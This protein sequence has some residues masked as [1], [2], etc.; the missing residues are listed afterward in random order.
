LQRIFCI[1]KARL[2]LELQQ[3]VIQGGRISLTTD[4]WSTRNYSEYAAVTA[5]WISDKWQLRCTVLDVIELREPI[6]SGEYLAEQLLAVTN[7]YHITPAVFT[8]TCDNA[9]T[10]TVM[11]SEYENLV[12]M[13]E[14]TL[15]Q[16]WAYITKEGNVRCIGHIINLAVQAALASL[17]AVP[18]D[19]PDAYRL[20]YEAARVPLLLENESV[21]VLSKL[22]RYIY[23]FRNR[24][25]WKDA[26]KKQCKAAN[27]EFKQLSLNMP[28]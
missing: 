18:T 23:V 24:R 26:L 3:H 15:Q 14:T 9:S 1:H 2:Q 4:T 22:R 20:E 7:D 21:A 12:Y 11:L 13:H 25:Q 28:V 27:I 5:H 6:H 17:K 19:E 8:I 16:P 10:N